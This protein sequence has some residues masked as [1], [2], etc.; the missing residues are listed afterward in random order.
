VAAEVPPIIRE[1]DLIGFRREFR[2]VLK[3]ELPRWHPPDPHATL[4]R[5][6]PKDT[7]DTKEAPRNWRE[8]LE[9]RE[10]LRKRSEAQREAE[11]EVARLRKALGRPDELLEGLLEPLTWLGVRILERA[12]PRDRPRVAAR[13]VRYVVPPATT[14]DTFLEQEL[15]RLDP[16]DFPRRLHSDL[17]QLLPLFRLLYRGGQKELEQR[18]MKLLKTEIRKM[19]LRSP[20]LSQSPVAK[21]V[22]NALLSDEPAEEIRKL[23]SAVGWNQ[24]E[25]AA[26][27]TYHRSTISHWIAGERLRVSTFN[28]LIEVLKKKLAEVLK[29]ASAQK[30]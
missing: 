17:K 2:K 16:S 26:A 4:K 28:Q 8:A 13:F 30:T 3:Y 6:L 24:A 11:R 18:L 22:R 7:E 25:W 12:K 21:R 19:F 1:Q 5:R 20:S 9:D 27:A 23:L 29:K 14:G 10:Y 15:E